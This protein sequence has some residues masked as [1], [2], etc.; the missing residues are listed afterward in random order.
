MGQ[1]LS[2]SRD[3]AAHVEVIAPKEGPRQPGRSGAEP[4]VLGEDEIG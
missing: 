2:K 4:R 3:L 1:P